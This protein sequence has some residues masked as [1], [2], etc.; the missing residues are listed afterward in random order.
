M[1]L[2]ST[3]FKFKLFEMDENERC[4]A[5][6]SVENIGA[7]GSCTVSV[8]SQKIKDACACADHTA[9]LEL[10]M[11]KLKAQGLDVD[12]A[13]IDAVGY[14]AVHGGHI[15]G[16]YPLN[17]ELMQEMENMTDFA[18]AH[19]P[20][21]L[22]MMRSLQEKYP[23]LIQIACFETAF[24]ASV[25]SERKVYGV[26]YEWI[27]K[28]GIRR[29]GFHGNSHSYIAWKM[30]QV[31]PEARRVISVHLG[32][33]C[34]LCAI[35]DSK[36]I[37]NSMGATP[38]SGVF[39][40]NRVGDLDVFCLPVLA[41]HLGGYENVMKLL[42]ENSGLLG[43]SGVSNDMRKVE[44]AAVKGNAQ[45]Q[46][47]LDA[48]LDTIIGY[49]GMYTA[50]LGGADAICFTGGIGTN[51]AEMRKKVAERL[52]FICAKVDDTL[53]K[54]QGLEGKFSTSDSGVELWVFETNEELMVARECMKVL[55][56]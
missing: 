28:Y 14:K 33:S 5:S 16:A 49:I 3:S 12:I 30:A 41:R 27:E 34:S 43:L 13:S 31:S 22:R 44:D 51:D 1:N 36:S 18:P 55:Q 35:R 46:L 50:Y 39:H 7:A 19:N 10:C 29:Y 8:I 4:L 15:S 2:G 17:E 25:P 6:G 52:T 42:A 54:Q 40:N 45:A 23:Y 11:K 24:H 56:E 53:N 38:Q 47:A 20:V 9:A 32:G 21:Y 48:F 37:A 26:P